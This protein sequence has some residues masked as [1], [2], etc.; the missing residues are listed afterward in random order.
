MPKPQSPRRGPHRVGGNQRLGE[1]CIEGNTVQE[2]VVQ[3]LRE[4][5]DY[6]ELKCPL[7]AYI[8]QELE[9]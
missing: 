1:Y 6:P 5:H 9:N 8:L 4:H 2:I 3:A 7:E